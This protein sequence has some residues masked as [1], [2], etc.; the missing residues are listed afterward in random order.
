MPPIPGLDGVPALDNRL[1][2]ALNELPGHLVIIGGS[3]I[4]LEMA[5]IF[6]RLGADV[7]VIEGGPAS[8]RAKIPTFRR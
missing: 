2:L 4:G 6:R 7:T 3:Y 5:Q 8:P 1:L